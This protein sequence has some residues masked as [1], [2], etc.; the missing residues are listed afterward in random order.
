MPTRL[1]VARNGLIQKIKNL[2]SL[3]GPIGVDVY[4]QMCLYD[5]EYGYYITKKPIGEKGDFIT[6]PEISQMFGEMIGIWAFLKWQ[7]L[8]TPRRLQIVELGAG[9]G[10]LLVDALRSFRALA[11]SYDIP[12]IEIAI[13]ETNP[14]LM[15]LQRIALKGEN[16]EWFDEFS[17]FVK[18]QLKAPTIIIANEFFDCLPIKQFVKAN[19][20]WHERH[21]G[22]GM[23]GELSFGLG[24]A[25]GAKIGPKIDNNTANRENGEI[26]EFAPQLQNNMREIFSALEKFSGAALIV[27]YGY[28]NEYSGDTLQALRGHKKVSVLENCGNSDITAHVD[29]NAIEEIAK[30]HENLDFKVQTQSEFLC[31]YGIIARAQKLIATN[32]EKRNGI[33]QD[34]E[35]LIGLDQMGELFKVFECN[36]KTK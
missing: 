31:K 5:Q 16:I 8:G 20:I 10:T 3:T 22:F 27:D 24:P 29:F 28:F 33:E 15:D 34:L 26:Y 11:K 17:L 21:I 36:S 6:A 13:I 4:M 35:R 9:R 25:I 14:H 7:D 12:S 1:Q 30:T 32:L 2:I 18:E 19:N 23:N